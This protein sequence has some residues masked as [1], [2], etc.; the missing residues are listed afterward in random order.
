MRLFFSE[1][2]PDYSRYRYPYVVWA[3]PDAGETP[4]D[5]FE[6]GFL[7]ASPG[8]D[9]FYLVRQLRLPLRTFKP[10]SENRRI[11]RKGEGWTARVIERSAFD[12]NEAR[13]KAWIDYAADRFGEGVMHQKRL[14][15]LM[16]SPVISHLMVFEDALQ[17]GR[18]IGV[19]LMYLEPPRVAYY[20]Y[21][22]Y[23]LGLLNRSA[24]LFMMNQA[25]VHFSEAGFDHLYLGTCYSERALYKTQFKGVQ[26]FNSF[27]WSDNLQELKYL[28]KRDGKSLHAFQDPE[29]QAFHGGLS[30]MLAAPGFRVLPSK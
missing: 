26:F 16:S 3:V 9:C 4:A 1:S 21:A 23:D 18:E 17:G 15:T 29:Y 12:Y 6:A 20:Y 10:G 30:N 13:R 24:G 25:A 14:D 28:V 5:F 7:P 2:E 11:L 27:K 8:L 22:F 19:V